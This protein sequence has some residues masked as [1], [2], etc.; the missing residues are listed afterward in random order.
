[1]E[2][3]LS[4]IDAAKRGQ[5]D[6][7]CLVELR[8]K[9]AQPLAASAKSVKMSSAIGLA[10]RK[11]QRVLDTFLGRRRRTALRGRIAASGRASAAG[12]ASSRVTKTASRRTSAPAAAA[13][14][15]GSQAKSKSSR[16][17]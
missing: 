17:I 6:K 12:K 4:D 10:L 5:A 1:V 11:A 14:K 8:P 16:K 15:A 3:H 7:R 9:R 13:K 2:I